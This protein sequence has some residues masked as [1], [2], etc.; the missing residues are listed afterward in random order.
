[1]ADAGTSNPQRAGL[2]VTNARLMNWMHPAFV[3]A[4]SYAIAAVLTHRFARN[5]PSFV[6]AASTFPCLPF[7][8]PIG[9]E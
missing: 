9:A 6:K 2:R 8:R 7:R 4:G 1:M 3:T 5:T